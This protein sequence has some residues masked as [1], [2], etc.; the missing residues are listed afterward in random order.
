M[1][2]LTP[3]AILEEICDIEVAAPNTIVETKKVTLNP[4][5][6]AEFLSTLMAR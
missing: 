6:L 2:Q 1:N 5:K 3:G 4:H